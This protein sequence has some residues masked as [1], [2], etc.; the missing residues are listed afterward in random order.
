MV[1][2]C[3]I[4]LEFLSLTIIIESGIV[5]CSSHVTSQNHKH[6]FPKTWSG[7]LVIYQDPHNQMVLEKEK[8]VH[9]QRIQQ[10][11]RVRF[12]LLCTVTM[13]ISIPLTSCIVIWYRSAFWQWICHCSKHQRKSNTSFSKLMVISSGFLVRWSLHSRSWYIH[14]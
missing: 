3:S 5:L 2:S 8:D 13:S 6:S 12:Y 9:Q 4:N 14:I 10:S 7:S 1:R 11:C